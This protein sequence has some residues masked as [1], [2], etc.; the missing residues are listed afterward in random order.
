MTPATTWLEDEMESVALAFGL[1]GVDIKGGQED[2]AKVLPPEAL[3]LSRN[4]PHVVVLI[5]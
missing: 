4:A 2:G 1:G 3:L 5:V